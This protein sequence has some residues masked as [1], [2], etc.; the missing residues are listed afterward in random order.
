M[1]NEKL[2]EYIKANLAKGHSLKEVRKFI[3]AY[4][5]SQSEFDEAVLLAS[6]SGSKKITM[7]P[8][9]G[10]GGVGV[11]AGGEEPVVKKKG[12]KKLILGLII[13]IVV[14]FIFLFVIADVLNYFSELYPDTVLPFNV[15]SW[16]P[17]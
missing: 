5:W 10:K 17:I 16:L 3:V 2:V 9:P 8:E 1:V 13:L 7:P 15:S 6:G 4:G 12:H 14:I 11:E